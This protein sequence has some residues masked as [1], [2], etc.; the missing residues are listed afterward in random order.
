MQSGNPW[1]R[2]EFKVKRRPLHP[3]HQPQP[4]QTT[5]HTCHSSCHRRRLCHSKLPSSRPHQPRPD[6]P[7]STSPLHPA[8]TA[9]LAQGQ[10]VESLPAPRP[11]SRLLWPPTA[12]RP[13]WQLSASTAAGAIILRFLVGYALLTEEQMYYAPAPQAAPA[14]KEKKDRGCLAAW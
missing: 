6:N 3:S 13:V 5:T 14:P 10:H 8:P 4:Y 9:N 11:E 12:E 7:I 2:V 1:A